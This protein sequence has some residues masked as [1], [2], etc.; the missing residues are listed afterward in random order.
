PNA[1]LTFEWDFDADG[2]YDAEGETVTHTFT[3]L[4]R[5]DVQLRVTDPQGNYGL[6]VQ[7]IT[8]GNTAPVVTLDQPNGAIFDWGDAVPYTVSVHDAEDGDEPVCSDIQY[9]FGLGHNE[10]A[11]PEVS[12]SATETEAGCGFTIQTSPDAVEHGAGEKIYGTLVV[13]YTDEPQGD[14]PAITG[15]ATHVLKPEVQQAE[16]FDA[17]EGVEVVEDAAADAGRYVT[18]FDE[19]DSFTYRPLALVHAPTGETIDE[20]T[21]RGSGEGTVTLGWQADGSDAAETLAD[22]AFTGEGWQDVTQAL[23]GVPE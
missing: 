10:H 13:T 17:S 5:F 19:G 22:F 9:T 16:W 12:G 14:V 3:E 2:E 4:G 20:I 1:E 23:T 6:A 21:V 11:H 15:E 18:S 8:V 7:P